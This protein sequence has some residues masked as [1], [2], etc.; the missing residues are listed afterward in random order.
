MR[1]NKILIFP[2]VLAAFASCQ[3]DIPYDFDKAED[4]VVMNAQL[5]PSAHRKAL[6]R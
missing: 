2:L 4:K 3:K 5:F 6:K 1:T